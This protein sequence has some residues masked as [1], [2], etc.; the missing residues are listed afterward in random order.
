MRLYV[1]TQTD[2]LVN[3]LQRIP[4]R[5]TQEEEERES[6]RQHEELIDAIEGSSAQT[7]GSVEKKSGGLFGGISSLFKGLGK[8]ATLGLGFDFRIERN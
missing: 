5:E 2:S 4:S 6:D 7:T 1:E 3:A 8:I